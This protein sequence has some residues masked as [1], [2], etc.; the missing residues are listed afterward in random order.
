MRLNTAIS[1]D[2]N[3]II[4]R[5]KL[6]YWL[7]T[8]S[9]NAGPKLKEFQIQ[10]IVSGFKFQITTMTFQTTM[11]FGLEAF[12]NGVVILIFMILILVIL[13]IYPEIP[14]ITRGL[15]IEFS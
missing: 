8:V 3:A 7:K 14:W 4:L 12:I 9:D 13:I 11:L 2:V 15:S 5:I 1:L 6:K 10:T